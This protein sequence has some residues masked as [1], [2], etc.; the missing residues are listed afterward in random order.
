VTHPGENVPVDGGEGESI[1]EVFGVL[2]A[3]HEVTLTASPQRMTVI[4]MKVF[5]KMGQ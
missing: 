5:G 2:V 1:H 4:E 3:A